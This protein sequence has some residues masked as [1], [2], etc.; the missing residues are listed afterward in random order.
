MEQKGNNQPDK[1][2][3]QPNNEDEVLNLD[4]LMDV[5]GGEEGDPTQNCGLGCYL[6]GMVKKGDTTE[7]G[8]GQI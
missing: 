2:F 6:S 4:E 5:Q 1:S 7:D 8:K 3:I